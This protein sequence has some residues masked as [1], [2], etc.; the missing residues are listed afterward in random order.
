MPVPDD[1]PL[2]KRV[3]GQIPISLWAEFRRKCAEEG[4]SV[5]DMLHHLIQQFVTG[6]A[7]KNG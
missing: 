1:S 3:T 6:G 5:A 7:N 4:K 2:Q